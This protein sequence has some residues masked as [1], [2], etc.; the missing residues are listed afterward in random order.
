[1]SWTPSITALGSTRLHLLRCR[2]RPPLLQCPAAASAAGP[3]STRPPQHA[4]ASQVPPGDSGTART[5]LQRVLLSAV[6]VAAVVAAFVSPMPASA[7]GFPGLQFAPRAETTAPSKD[8]T[9]ESK[10]RAGAAAGPAYMQIGLGCPMHVGREIVT[11]SNCQPLPPPLCAQQPAPSPSELTPDELNTVR[12]FNSASPSVVNVSNI[13]LVSRSR[14]SLDVMRLPLGSGSGFV[15]DTEG[16]V[17]TNFHVVRGS[18]ELQV[19]LIDQSV[20]TARIVSGE[21]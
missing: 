9:L 13:Q 5:A 1:M 15:W 12:L 11:P 21:Q 16:H 14:F 8:A 2:S 19:T 10:A 7:L 6:G 18:S 4:A 20:Y 3:G 17:V